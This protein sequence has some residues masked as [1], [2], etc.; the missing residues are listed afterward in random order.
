VGLGLGGEWAAGSVLVAET[1][2]PKHR[3][4]AMGLMQSGWAL[5]YIAASILA[6]YVIPAFGWRPLFVIGIV[7]ALATLWI[8]KSI[9]EPASWRASDFK[10]D[11][12]H[13]AAW[14]SMFKMPLLRTTAIT[15]FI[16]TSV[17]FAYWG[18]FTWLPTFLA[19]PI[20]SGGAGLGLVKSSE[21]VVIVQLGAFLGY[22]TFGLFADRFG[23]RPAFF[24]FLALA[25]LVVPVYG[26][27]G[28]HEVWLFVMGPLIGYFGHGY[29]SV[30]G[31]LLS[32]LFPGPVRGSAQGFTFNFGRALSAL[33]PFTIGALADRF[34]IGSALA[35]TSL[36]FLIGGA[37]IYLLPETA[38]KQLV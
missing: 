26:Q 6:A 5:G 10:V 16:S 34:G 33:A 25:A 15:C 22:I 11:A 17:L 12:A 28:G 23:R 3:G 7:P 31:S 32:E 19:A 14:R 29:F 20:S 37:S 38:G 13:P 4:K 36:F 2:N 1:W 35:L 9:P 27:L 8:R 30:F 21:W 24:W 18:L